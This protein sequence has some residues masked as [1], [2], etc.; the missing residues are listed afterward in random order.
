MLML[1][2]GRM[3]KEAGAVILEGWHFEIVEMVNK[4]IDKL[5]SSRQFDTV[6]VVNNL[7]PARP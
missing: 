4:T 3:H 6:L 7:D 2:T 5:L 1:V